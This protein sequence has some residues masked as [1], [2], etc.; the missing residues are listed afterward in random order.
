MAYRSGWLTR[1]TSL[2]RMARVQA[3]ELRETWL[4]RRW[5]MATVA[6]DTAGSGEDSHPVDVPYLLRSNGADV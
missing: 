2:V 5:G 3:V 1:R 6:V 4:D